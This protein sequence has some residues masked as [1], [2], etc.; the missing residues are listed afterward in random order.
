MRI[1]SGD[2]RS[3]EAHEALVLEPL[4][5]CACTQETQLHTCPVLAHGSRDMR[6]MQSAA[7][8]YQGIAGSEQR[9]FER[10]R[11]IPLPQYVV[12][13]RRNRQDLLQPTRDDLET[14]RVGSAGRQCDPASQ[15][16]D[17]SIRR[18]G[19][20]AESEKIE[21]ERAILMP[22]VRG[23][24]LRVI[25]RGILSPHPRLVEIQ[26]DACAERVFEQLKNR[27][28]NKCSQQTRSIDFSE[29]G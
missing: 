28:A 11:G 20:A 18:R 29:H 27:I 15:H 17:Q 13:Q 8:K 24:Q 4:R 10:I 21:P 16:V 19:A 1:H 23:M 2:S 7:A 22:A 12:G 3:I 25:R 14:G 6:S 5:N 9:T 26:D